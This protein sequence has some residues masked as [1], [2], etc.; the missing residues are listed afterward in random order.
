MQTWFFFFNSEKKDFM[1][2]MEELVERGNA[3]G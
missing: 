1:Q 2:F 3:V